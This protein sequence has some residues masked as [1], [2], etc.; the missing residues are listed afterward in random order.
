MQTNR[1]STPGPLVYAIGGNED[2]QYYQA[3]VATTGARLQPFATPL[4]GLQAFLGAPPQMLIL[5]LDVAGP[6]S[7]AF[8]RLLRASPWHQ[9]IPI[10]ACSSQCATPERQQELFNAGADGYLEKPFVDE[11]FIEALQSLL[12]ESSAGPPAEN[13][14]EATGQPDMPI[15]SLTPSDASGGDLRSPISTR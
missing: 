15:I 4:K 14:V 8:L 2:L 10:L 3:V 11:E 6:A 12:E 9:S 7:L 13:V 1:F 5:D